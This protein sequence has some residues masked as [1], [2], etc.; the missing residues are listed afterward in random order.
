MV[1][2]LQ[3][4]IWG[5]TSRPVPPT[6][7]RALGEAGGIVLL[8]ELRG[9][10][11]GFAFGFTGRAR[12]GSAYHRSHAAGLLARARGRGLG[13][14][15]KQAQRR[16]A[17]R[18]G[19]ERMVWTF[20]PA[21][22]ANAHFNLRRL[23][24]LARGFQRDYYGARVDAL[25][26]QGPSDRLIAEWWLSPGLERRLREVRRGPGTWVWLPAPAELLRPSQRGRQRLRQQLESGFS[27][28]LG[29]VDFDRERSA[30]RFAELPPETPAPAEAGGRAQASERRSSASASSSEP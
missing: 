1:S 25:N 21:L 26:R 2:Q 17:L 24:A 22:A 27:Q 16:E 7:L 28:G 23:G 14:A 13:F 29:I 19:L 6:M 3:Q 10:P 9:E 18:L 12:D 15:L 8:G 4:E 5:P 11:V 20:D 30:Y